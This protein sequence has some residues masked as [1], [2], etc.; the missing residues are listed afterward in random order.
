MRFRAGWDD[1]ECAPLR[2]AHIQRKEYFYFAFVAACGPLQT[3]FSRE[4]S[5]RE[6]AAVALVSCGNIRAVG[7]GLRP[8]RLLTT[9]A[10]TSPKGRGKSTAGNLL[11]TPNALATNVTAWLSLRESWRGS[12]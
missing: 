6:T 1:L 4:G 5:W 10:S 9:F 8:L 11:I 3:L 2:S 12:A 7:G